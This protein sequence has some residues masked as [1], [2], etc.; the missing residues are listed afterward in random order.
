L[1]DNK[2]KLELAWLIFW[3]IIYCY[4]RPLSLFFFPVRKLLWWT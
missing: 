1:T 2:L 4:I 3:G